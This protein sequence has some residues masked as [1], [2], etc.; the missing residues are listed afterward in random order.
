[1]LGEEELKGELS[2]RVELSML[3]EVLMVELSLA[4]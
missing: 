3:K 2:R 1:M 4:C